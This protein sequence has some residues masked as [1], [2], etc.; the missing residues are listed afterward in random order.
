MPKGEG[1][2]IDLQNG[3]HIGILEH[4]YAVIGDPARYRVTPEEIAGKDR[5]EILRLTLSR[6]FVRVRA[7][8]EWLVAEF[9]APEDEALPLINGFLLD[10]GFVGHRQLRLRDHREHRQLDCTA[11]EL[12]DSL[13]AA[14]KWQAMSPA[15]ETRPGEDQ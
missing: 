5:S 13:P 12:L 9:N 4:R 3:E 7:D 10:K 1:W 2:F 14:G 6:G 15:P 11:D 8:K